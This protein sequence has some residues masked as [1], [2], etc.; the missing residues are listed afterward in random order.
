MKTSNFSNDYLRY[1]CEKIIHN[2]RKHKL[3]G[4]F[5]ADLLKH[6]TN[7]NT[8]FFDKMYSYSLHPHVR[9]PTCKSVKLKS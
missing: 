5:N 2:R 3:I 4:A 7:S 9:P 8:F 1:P 6:A